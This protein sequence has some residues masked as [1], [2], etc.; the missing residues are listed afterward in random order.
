M[1]KLKDEGIGTGGGGMGMGMMGGMGGAAAGK[2]VSK[3]GGSFLSK[4]SKVG[5]A[6]P[7]IGGVLTAGLGLM[8]GESVAKAGSRGVGTTVG[9][10]AG[11]ALGASLG[12]V[13][14]FVGGLI[15]GMLGDVLGGL[16]GDFLDNLGNI[17]TMKKPPEEPQNPPQVGQK[18]NVTLA[19]LTQSGL[20][21]KEG[22][23]KEGGTV[24]ENVKAG[25]NMIMKSKQL[26]SRSKPDQ[27]TSL[28][29]DLHKE[30]EH[31][32]GNAFDFTVGDKPS[33]EE[34]RAIIKQIRDNDPN[35]SNVIDEYNHP[36]TNSTGGHFHVQY[37]SDNPK[38]ES[39]EPPA[40]PAKPSETA[41]TSPA[42]TKSDKE[43]GR[44]IKRSESPSPTP[45]S[46]DQALYNINQ[47][48]YTQG[49]IN[50]NKKWDDAIAMAA[51]HSKSLATA[52]APPSF[53]TDSGPQKDNQLYN[54]SI[55]TGIIKDQAQAKQVQSV[56]VLQDNSVKSS[57][58]SS[59]KEA[60]DR[61][62]P[63][64]NYF[65]NVDGTS[66]AC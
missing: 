56:V 13:G 35:V 53:V 48:S 64:P 55:Q 43:D 20:N 34:G 41:V 28:N 4:V 31:P 7:I 57:T 63:I 62:L 22:A 8:Q 44:P 60:R 59:Q 15:G 45:Q 49:I 39:I 2:V 9:S 10:I 16:F 50:E 40:A 33:E 52:S 66:C 26:G 47:E 65:Y 11:A 17:L 38:T 23:M 27:I 54:K 29:D 18:N 25:A 46:F 51:S 14:M 61:F 12:P 5:K 3:G 24:S 1:T 37:K 58:T 36:S 6:T 42:P 32:K 21:I 19:E 30:F